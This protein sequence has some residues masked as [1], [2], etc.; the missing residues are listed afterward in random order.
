MD[1]MGRDPSNPEDRSILDA[2]GDF[3]ETIRGQLP[4]DLEDLKDI[5]E[6]LIRTM[7]GI[8]EDCETWAGRASDE[9]GTYDGW[10]GC[11]HWRNFSIPGLDIPLPPEWLTLA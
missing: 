5:A 4:T 7:S 3:L 1:Y 2:A 9:R 8:S 6:G 10:K 11:K